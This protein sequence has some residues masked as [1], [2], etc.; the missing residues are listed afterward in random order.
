MNDRCNSYHNIKS[1]LFN[2]FKV[3]NFSNDLL[4]MRLI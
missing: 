3:I 1:K 4:K 2:E